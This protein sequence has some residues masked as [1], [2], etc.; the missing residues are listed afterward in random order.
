M[1]GWQV[2]A[3]S[4]L[5]DAAAADAALASLPQFAG[6]SREL[7]PLR[8]GHTNRNYRL[9]TSEGR[10]YVA[11]FSA[12]DPSGL[13]ID[14]DAEAANTA[15]AAAL[16][17]GPEVAAYAPQ[18]G[19]LVTSWIDGRTLSP[20]D[21]ADE[22]ILRRVAALARSLHSGPRFAGDFDV[23]AI[24]RRYL[25]LVRA[26][27]YHLPP[28]YLELQPLIDRLEGVLAAGA[29][30]TLPCHC[31]LVAANIVDAGDRL[32]FI[33]YEYAGNT[34]PAFELGNLWS[35]AGLGGERLAYLV[36]AYFGRP[37]P[38]QAARARL[39]GLVSLYSWTLWASIQEAVGGVD[40]DFRSWGRERYERAR[41]ELTSSGLE[42]AVDA[43][44][45]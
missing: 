19:L 38:A 34:D 42:A 24:Q 8:G 2:A 23:F 1:R 41:G 22:T 7:T 39:Y 29:A 43:A 26:S 31:D 3:G 44:C 6:T 10:R 5:P 36:E 15:A 40:F 21:L 37:D 45:E 32:W 4:G 18:H 28:D 35:E 11:R 14:R 17:V 9:V 30:A 33:D 16:G 20:A 13:G 25:E 27:G 12:S